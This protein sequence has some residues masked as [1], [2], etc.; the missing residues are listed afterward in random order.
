MPRVLTRNGIVTIPVSGATAAYVS[1]AA[2]QGWLSA[3]SLLRRLRLTESA[4]SSGVSDWKNGP[5]VPLSF[6][7]FAI[8]MLSFAT[9]AG[10]FTFAFGV[11][12]SSEIADIQD[13][14]T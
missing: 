6:A 4:I 10:S 5:T 12:A 2:C 9:F 3:V 11:C 8:L 1:F 7:A 13:S 14:N